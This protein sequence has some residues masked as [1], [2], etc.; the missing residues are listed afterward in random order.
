MLP[1]LASPTHSAK[2]RDRIQEVWNA[3]LI[4][5]TQTTA[6]WKRLLDRSPFRLRIVQQVV[7][8]LIRC[9]W[10]VTVVVATAAS[11]PWE[12]IMQ[13]KIVEDGFHYERATEATTTKREKTNAAIWMTPVYAKG[14]RRCTPVSGD[15][16][17]ERGGAPRRSAVFERFAPR[18][19][20]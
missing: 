7:K 6:F 5:A 8:L 10:I 20:K 9:A 17:G 1:G 4:A 3:Y 2:V 16:L 19:E 15:R 18:E 12:G 14:R 11:K 13:T